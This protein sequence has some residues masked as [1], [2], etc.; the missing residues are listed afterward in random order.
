MTLPLAGLSNS[1]YSYKKQNKTF[2]NQTIQIKFLSWD[3]CKE[4]ERR[5][6]KIECSKMLWYLESDRMLNF[7]QEGN[8]RILMGEGECE[9]LAQKSKDHASLKGELSAR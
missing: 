6:L 2:E 9:Q 3:I 4:F 5:K 8:D 1:T 7:K